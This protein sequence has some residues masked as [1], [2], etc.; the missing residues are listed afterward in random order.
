ME[1]QA[2]QLS[3]LRL[4]GNEGMERNMETTILGYGSIP[5]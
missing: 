2:Q 3:Y 4:A 5:P 1:A